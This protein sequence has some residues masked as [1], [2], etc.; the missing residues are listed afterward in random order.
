MI[1]VY[2]RYIYGYLTRMAMGR[3]MGRLVQYHLRTGR[4]LVKWLEISSRGFH[5]EQPTGH[6][7]TVSPRRKFLPNSKLY[8]TKDRSRGATLIQR[9]MA[10]PTEYI[11]YDYHLLYQ[12]LIMDMHDELKGFYIFYFHNW[13]TFL[14]FG[15]LNDLG[16]SSQAI[17]SHI[18][19]V[20]KLNFVL[21]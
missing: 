11:Q 10:I 8:S 7:A 4:P 9:L 17:F 2:P 12:W 14:E 1:H 21:I 16:P 15:C 20:I 5:P 18:W 3:G 13:S 19:N 6:T